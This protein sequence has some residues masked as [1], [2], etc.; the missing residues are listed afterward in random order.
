MFRRP[1]WI[2][3]ALWGTVVCAIAAPADDL[4]LAQ[5]RWF[6][7]RT[8]H[9]NIY[10]CGKLPDGYKLAGR[11]EQ[12]C[13]AYS[14]LAGSQAVDSPP[15]VVMAF[16]DHESMTPY[17][18]LYQGKPNN[19]AAFFQHGTDENLIVLSLP[20][21]GSPDTGMEV[22]FHEYTHLLFRRNDRIW[23]LWLKEGMAEI[24][25]T[26]E[27]TGQSAR[28]AGPIPWHLQ[29]LRQNPLMPLGE[30]FS[31][32]HDSPQY[33]E[34]DR[35]GMFY[36][37]SWLLTHFLMAGDNGQYR[38]R[39]GQFTALLRQGRLPVPAFTNAM[40]AS[41]TAVEAG[42]RRYLEHGA[43]T[44]VELSLT[45]DISAPIN[46]TT[47]YLTPVEIYFRLGD[48][49][50]RINRLDAAEARFTEAKKI[51]PASPLP[52]EGLGL[53]AN[54]RDQH[55]AALRHLQTAI[56]LGSTS[57][58]AYYLC[59]SEEYRATAADGED[60]YAR[61]KK[62]QAAE[63]LGHLQRSIELMP[64]FGPAQQL[65]GFFET[66]QGE[67]LAD[68]GRHLQRAIQLEPENQA[69][70][71]SL[72]QYQYRMRN[73]AAA[74]QTLESLLHPYVDEKLRTAAE[75]LLKEIDRRYPV[76]R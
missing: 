42:L 44:P 75:E 37:E 25:S 3:V 57:F 21:P 54:E 40:Q 26:F 16:P 8:A 65:L 43:I 7:A 9:F 52:E 59:A 53:V 49:L 39:F 17:L 63:I 61:I 2:L 64:D 69:Y 45:S 76:G 70:V 22:I 68:A 73:A 51:A 15:I 24:Y 31:V 4:P 60:R 32:T 72:A 34:R 46:L 41:L 14:Q 67:H 12:F 36:A 29:T 62:N 11:L 5:R 71:F 66:V 20:E 74:R 13:K 27:T 6:E 55:D 23:P 38:T 33:N 35:Q 19:M 56:Q 28:I 48:E 47:R 50:L 18:P 1:F 58:L 30:L 10:S